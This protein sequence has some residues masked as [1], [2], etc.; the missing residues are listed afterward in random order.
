MTS[1]V[2]GMVLDFPQII[3]RWQKVESI[4]ASKAIAWLTN[5]FKINTLPYYC[6]APCKT[7]EA[8]QQRGQ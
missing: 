4:A 3:S 6:V 1:G 2:G 8:H 5:E 7:R